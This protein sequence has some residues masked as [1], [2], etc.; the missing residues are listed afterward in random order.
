[1]KLK[2]KEKIKE[3]DNEQEEDD[4]KSHRFDKQH[5][6]SEATRLDR[7]MHDLAVPLQEKVPLQIAQEY[8]SVYGSE[9]ERMKIADLV[10]KEGLVRIA[11][12]FVMAKIQD[13]VDLSWHLDKYNKE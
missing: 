6:K 4:L 9:G 3:I 5:L 1:M 10:D 12:I 7:M 8:F 13:N 11:D 2:I